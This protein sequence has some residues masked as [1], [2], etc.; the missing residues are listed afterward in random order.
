MTV[1]NTNSPSQC[2]YITAGLLD[3]FKLNLHKKKFTTPNKEWREKK[4]I[5][6]TV[7]HAKYAFR[8]E[9]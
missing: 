6:F 3:I 7:L 9:Y 2:Y 1:I 8:M 4:C 5:Y